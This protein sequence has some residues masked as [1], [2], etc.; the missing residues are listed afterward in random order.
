VA[1]Y[2]YA[3]NLTYERGDADRPTG[4]ALLYFTTGS[5]ERVLATYLIVPPISMNL[6]RYM[7]PMFA[8]NLPVGGLE[9][10]RPVPLPP[11]PEEA[12]GRAY[13]QRLA[14]VRGDD[15]IYGGTVLD[16]EPQRL[17]LETGY[18]AE[19]YATGYQTYT[20]DLLIVESSGATPELDAAAAVY[21]AMGEG[22]RLAELTKLTGTLRG[23]TE[24]GDTRGVA[25]ASREM[26]ALIE[27]LPA[28]Y[29]GTRLLAAAQE[30][31][32]HGRR[33][34]QLL[35]ERAYAMHRE[36]YL[37]LGRIDRE[38]EALD[39]SNDGDHNADTDASSRT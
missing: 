6:A 33:L 23:S 2:T 24:R 8:A 37:E 34:C 30:P 1:P 7:P 39:N 11:V 3:M 14:E 10:N 15:L 9:G 29:R 21:S 31:A 19:T 18:A 36:E 5:P 26:R 4:H 35:L 17:L 32:E 16:D 27:T 38:I 20:A 28:K 12:P 22:Q 25:E 13:L